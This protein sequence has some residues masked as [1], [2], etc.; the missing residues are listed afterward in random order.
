[1]KK[2]G[3]TF[4]LVRDNKI[5]MQQRDEN[6][7]K[8]PFKWCIPGGGSEKNEEYETTLLR[9]VKEEYDINLKLSDCYRFM[10]VDNQSGHS[11]VYICNVGHDK[12]PILQEGIAMK[13]MTI[14]EIENTE[15]GFDQESIVVALR[16]KIFNV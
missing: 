5:L 3:V 7:K 9:E 15:L 11:E 13:W 1:M 4:V 2:T 8:F 14:E 10:E 6:C 12:I 16:N